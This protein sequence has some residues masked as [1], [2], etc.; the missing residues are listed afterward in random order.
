MRK[1]RISSELL[2]SLQKSNPVKSF[3]KRAGILLASLSREP[4]N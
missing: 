4:K 1:F 2:R 3:A